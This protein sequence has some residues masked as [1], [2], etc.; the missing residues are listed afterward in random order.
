MSYAN[1]QTALNTH[2]QAIA[3]LP[4]L[5]LENTQNVGVTGVPF[6]RLTLL[7]A[8]PTQLTV[9]VNGKDQL[10]GLAQLDLFYPLNT[11]TATGNG[12][13]DTVIAT[14]TRGLTLTSAGTKIHIQLVWRETG[15][16][17]EQFY[18]VP[19]MVQ[20]SSITA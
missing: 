9:G 19:V 4:T 11:G 10:Q 15:R 18:Q 8:R 1:I 20:W 12:M 5:Q 14:F 2:I 6:S 16:R 17:I 3:G 7:P 13:A